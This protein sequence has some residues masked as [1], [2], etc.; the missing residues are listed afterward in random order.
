METNFR[1]V[2]LTQIHPSEPARPEDFHLTITENI[3]HDKIL[4]FKSKTKFQSI[5]L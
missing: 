2:K 1:K 3:Q 4:K 5:R